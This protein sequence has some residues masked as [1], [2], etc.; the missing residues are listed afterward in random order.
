M[1]ANAVDDTQGCCN[2]NKI[3]ERA[4]ALASRQP[5]VNDPNEENLQHNLDSSLSADAATRN[6][7]QD[8]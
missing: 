7:K 5:N 1:A 4:V 8:S 2:M 3:A 6:Q